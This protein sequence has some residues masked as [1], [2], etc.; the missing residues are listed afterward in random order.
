MTTEERFMKFIHIDGRRVTEPILGLGGSCIV[1]R[2]GQC[3]VKIPKLSRPLHEDATVSDHES[4]YD[5]KA[6]AIED[7]LNEKLV[8]Q[9]LGI[10][11]QIVECYNASDSEPMIKMKIMH[12]GNLRSFVQKGDIGKSQ[13]L[14]WLIEI[15]SVLDFVHEKKVIFGDVRLDN[16]LLDETLRIK[17]S[18]F[19]NST[20]MPLDWDLSTADDQGYSVQTDIGQFGVLIYEMSTSERCDF[21]LWRDSNKKSATWPQRSNLPKTHGKWLGDVIERCWTH[22]FATIMELREELE[23]CALMR[24]GDH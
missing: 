22:G 4:D 23:S 12:N 10:H 14:G 11:P 18:D 6:A 2:Q 20:L 19:G 13:Q 5:E 17:L 21:D 9:R 8:Y 16:C 3:A 1:I 7:L 15:A 24:R